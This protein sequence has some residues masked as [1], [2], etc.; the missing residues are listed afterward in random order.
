MKHY[1]LSNI[2][3]HTR[4]ATNGDQVPVLLSSSLQPDGITDRLVFTAVHH[5]ESHAFRLA[6]VRGRNWLPHFIHFHF[7]GQLTKIIIGCSVNLCCII[8]KPSNVKNP[9]EGWV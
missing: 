9:N 6:A 4:P 5:N 8:C 3:P 2:F 7:C 1:F